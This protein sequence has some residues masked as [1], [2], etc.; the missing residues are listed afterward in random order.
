M[1]LR[2][3]A[4]FQGLHYRTALKWYH[5]GVLPV[6]SWR[7]GKLI[8]VGP[9][10]PD[11]KA[12][13]TVA[14]YARVSSSGLSD[15]LDR[16]VSRLCAWATA[17]GYEVGKVVAEVG[18]G[19]DGKRR[20]LMRLLSDPDVGTII[21]ERRDR[22]ARFGFEVAESALLASGRKI[23]VVGDGEVDDD[24]VVDVTEVL[25]SMCARLYGRRSA[26]NR[27]Q[28]ALAAAGESDD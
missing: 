4:D 5:D 20:K 25:T 19:L 16:Q 26:K 18:S 11:H 15:D 10:L 28:R 17:Q 27:A 8:M 14:V 13:K 3:W 9:L 12:G 6:E 24:L 23:V 21:V 2:E 1:N 22:L 7:V